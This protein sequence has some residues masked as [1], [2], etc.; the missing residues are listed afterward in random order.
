MGMGCCDSELL[1]N[2]DETVTGIPTSGL[3]LA[4]CLFYVADIDK[5]YKLGSS[6][7]VHIVKKRPCERSSQHTCDTFISMYYT[8]LLTFYYVSYTQT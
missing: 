6:W 8:I 3:H 4:E 5:T 7:Q 1:I 2:Y